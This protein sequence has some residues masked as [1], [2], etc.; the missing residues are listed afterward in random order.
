[1]LINISVDQDLLRP[2]PSLGLLISSNNSLFVSQIR[3]LKQSRRF[4]YALFEAF[5]EITESLGGSCE[6]DREGIDADEGL[7]VAVEIEG[8]EGKFSAW[9]AAC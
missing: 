1:M 9:G 4:Q 5:L 7:A 2:R 8:V 3:L 6:V